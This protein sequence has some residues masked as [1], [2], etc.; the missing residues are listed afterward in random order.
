MSGGLSPGETGSETAMRDADIALYDSV[1]EAWWREDTRWLRILANM[2]P[3][4]L[5]HF[6]SAVPAWGGLDVLDIGC[7][8][9]FMAEALARR[10]ATVTGIDPAAEALAAARDHAAAEGLSIRYD[11]GMG[12]ALPYPDA[13]FD[14]VV[15]VDVLEHVADLDAV[16]AELTRVLRPGGWFLFDTINRGWLARLV[17]VTAAERLLGVLPRGTHDPA[18]FIDAAALREALVQRGFAVGRFRG[19]AP[20]GL[21]RRGDFTFGL[22]PLTAIVYIGTAQKGAQ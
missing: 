11:E 12:E 6:E 1:A 17:V 3:A 22:I 16:L 8:G 7:A 4:R 13:S 5:R 18:K 2:V 14:A 20:T 9:G 10:G 21:N 15:C 19:L